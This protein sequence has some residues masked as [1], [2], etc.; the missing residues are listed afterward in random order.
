[1]QWKAPMAVLMLALLPET[2]SAAFSGY[3]R[4]LVRHSGK[5]L[6]VTGNSTADGADVVQWPAPS[7][8]TNDQWE[9]VDVGSGYHRITARHSGKA[10]NVTGAGT[11]DGANVIQ[12]TY[13]SAHTHSQWQLTDAGSGYY[14]V[15][16]RHSGKVLNV[17]GAGTANGA[18]VDQATWA[19]GQHQM[20]RLVPVAA[21][22]LEGPGLPKLT[23]TSAELFKPIGTIAPPTIGGVPRGIGLTTM[24]KGWLATIPAAD[25]GKAGG[26]FAFYDMS[27][28]RAPVLVSKRDVTSLREQ[29]GFAR[30]APGAYPGDY[31]V[32]QAGTGIEFWDWTDIRNPVLLKAMVLPGTAFSDYATGSWWLAWQ[33]P[34]VYVAGS[35]NGI[36]V[37][38]ATDPHNP[39]LVKQMPTSQL[40]GFRI[41]PIFVVG[42]L[43]VATS[44]DFSGTST[45]VLTMD[46]SDPRNPV[47]IKTQKDGFP[48]FYSAFFNGDKLIGLGFRDHQVHV[49]DLTNPAAFPKVGA[50]GG[51]DRPA[52]ATVQ[53]GRALVG[54][55]KNFVKVDIRSAPFSI[56]GRGTSGISDRSED[57]ATPLGN[58]VLMSNDHPTGSAL[59]PHTTSPDNTGPSVTMVNPRN[60]ATNQRVTSRV[61]ITLSDW[62]DLR[63]VGSATFT[64]RPVGGAA[65]AGKYSGEQGILN[66][67]PD[68][69]LQPGTAYDVVIPA[70]GLKDF[71]GNGVPT[72]F[73]SRFTTAG[74]NPNNPPT[75]QARVNGPALVG[76]AVAFA[77]TGSSGG[78]LTYSWDF[79][80]G[81]P[82]TPFSAASTASHSYAAPGH[83]AAKVTARN[84]AGQSSSSFTQVVHNPLT[85]AKPAA[86]GPL[87]LDAARNRVWTV[88]PDTDTVTAIDTGSH[89]KVFE[90]P[91]GVNPRTLGRAPDGTIWV[92]NQGSATVSVLA[93]DTGNLVQTITLPAASRPYGI[94]F[95]PNGSAAYVTTQGTGQLLKLDPSTRAV[96]SSLGLGFPARGIAITHDSARILVTR[97]V[98]PSA[99][100]EVV[101][102]SG[103]TFQVVR[104]FPLAFDSG[105][106]GNTTGRGVPNYLSAIAISPDGRQ[107]RVPSKKDNTARG[108]FRDGQAL[109][110]ETTVRTILSYID[111][112]ANS[113]ALALRVD[114]N[115]RDMAQAVA[116]SPLGDYVFVATQGT[117]TVEVLSAYDNRL[118]TG[119]PDTGLAPQGLALSAD[120]RKLFVQN[121]MSRSVSI[122]DVSGIVDSTTNQFTKLAD[123]KTVAT[124]KLSA[125]V[126]KGK[127]VFYNAADPRMSLNNYIACASCHLDGGS[128]ERVWDFT[129]RGEGLRN[130]VTLRGRAGLL[131]GNVH[132]SANFDEI[133]DFENDIRGG[134]GGEGFL[135]DAAYN[136]G[137]RR[138]PLGD[139]KNGLS[140]DLDALAAYVSSLDDTGRSPFRNANGTLTSA[141]A[142]G[143]V[144]FDQLRCAAC[145][146]GREFTDSQSGFRHDVG[147]LKPSSGQR[148]G[149]P[150][151][152]IDTPTLSGVW[153]TAPYL[154]DG[155]SPNLL[156]VLTT[157][158]AVGAHGAVGS[159][160]TAEQ[161]QLVSYLQQVDEGEAAAAPSELFV[162]RLSG[163]Q[164][165][166]PV[167]TTAKGQAK[168]V[169]LADGVTALVSL[170]T[171]GIS[172]QTAAH[173]H[174]PA[175][176]GVEGAILF[177]L[178]NGAVRDFQI[179]LSSAQRQDLRDGRL[180][181]DV[182]TS[183][184]PGGAIRGQ[185]RSANTPQPLPTAAP[186]PGGF[187]G[188]YRITARHSGRSVVVT[189]ASTANGANVVQWA[190]TSAPAANDEWGFAPLG[191]GYYHLLAR[192][193]GLAMNVTG[194]STANGGDV[195]QWP[196]TSGTNDDWQPIDLGGGY[197]RIVNRNS[198]KVLN[199]AG[200]GT[201]DGANVD[202]WSWANV[203]QQ[204]FQIVAVP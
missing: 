17:A 59:I 198:G 104:T 89:A 96:V 22:G 25:S 18:N 120:G 143:R 90:K 197:Y 75:V 102:V 72:A 109:D 111:L 44:A 10:L 127:Q 204:Q 180:Y 95:A 32:L 3:Y 51:M 179:A 70:G 60:N 81:T 91:V 2:A 30:S 183:A 37:V 136:A 193:S 103:A 14:R 123:V 6:N 110:F 146:A 138:Q 140:P 66:F 74:T 86:A 185:L 1:M 144:L 87:G 121:F 137:T 23:F 49:W 62:I 192:H 73:T 42:N 5:A 124:E 172:G 78:S 168:I 165:V 139:P 158:N 126:L 52:Y 33:A 201:A 9:L 56:V 50:I 40:G 80:D 195:V 184:N 21:S 149:Q 97:F 26:G 161:Q 115:D 13:N 12:W 114:F 55:E 152:G 41:H 166:P 200:A 79:G 202:Q 101:E 93:G 27:N 64:V 68:Q 190:Y 118:A 63:S 122:Y 7:A 43:L 145:H 181:I 20:W 133:Q 167:T 39:V 177:T 125:T 88:N 71:S 69:P 151:D 107:A 34:F 16:A 178:P 159:L 108:L 164:A 15:T 187:S 174:G 170:T 141:G 106:D 98:S 31:V 77:I 19:S 46:I 45:G 171:S 128:D 169:V 191:G 130:T 83:Y 94:A 155:S 105:P 173:V 76:A 188:Y 176:A 82:A 35:G 112:G 142:A 4:I 36:Y 84:T 65:L 99:R 194:A 92:V 135:S 48:V 163:A 175:L 132:W 113:E 54:D 182:H 24:H 148:L 189:G 150:L 162:A 153:E 196:V 29:H 134:F 67:W 129:D 117:N 100:G 199:V 85:A 61:G 116:Y 11:A 186:T 53:D 57:I 38:D 203:N 58:F 131:H 8:Q 119:I 147:T 47:V 160:S 154:H 28:P 157:A 156:H